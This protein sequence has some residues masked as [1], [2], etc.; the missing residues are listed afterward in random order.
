MEKNSYIKHM[1]FPKKADTSKTAKAAFEVKWH[2]M[3]KNV[4]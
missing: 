4:K 3:K 1:H 2:G